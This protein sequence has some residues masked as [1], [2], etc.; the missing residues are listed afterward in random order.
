MTGSGAAEASEVAE[1]EPAGRFDGP[2]PAAC[3]NG[4][5]AS[6]DIVFSFPL[7]Y[8]LDDGATS[9]I[10]EI[11]EASPVALFALL[12]HNAC[13]F[14]GT[15]AHLNKMVRRGPSILRRL[16]IARMRADPFASCG[17]KMG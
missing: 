2:P 12:H 17:R 8:R 13:S 11:V 5:L 14:T 15:V 16:L 3:L 1:A 9:P 10:G 7:R 6:V 4:H